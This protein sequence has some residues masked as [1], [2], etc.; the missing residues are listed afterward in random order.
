[1]KKQIL[2]L[3]IL[4]LALYSC[5]KEDN[6]PSVFLEGT[7]QT[8]LESSE[9]N[10]VYSSE[11]TFSRSGNVLI[12]HFITPANSELRCLRGYSEGTYSLKGEDFTFS[13]TSSLG[14]DPATFDI[15][16]GCVPK[17][18]L[19]SNLNPTN[20]TQT[21]TLVLSDSHDSF[22]LEY[23]CNDMLGGMNNCIGAQVF[24]MVE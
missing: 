6:V 23:T 5:K 1:M 11:I 15:S 17:D 10:P 22:L 24:T 7:Y 8:Q 2:L 4:V 20:P 3:T 12:E 9:G 19:V 13:F 18:Q 21:G 16:D 14:P